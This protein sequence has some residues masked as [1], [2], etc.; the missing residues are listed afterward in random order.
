MSSR[1]WVAEMFDFLH[2]TVPTTLKELMEFRAEAVALR[3]PP[4]REQAVLDRVLWEACELRQQ[5]RNVLAKCPTSLRTSLESELL[6][7]DL[8]SEDVWNS[9]P[10]H[11][12]SELDWL[13]LEKEVQ[14]YGMAR[15]QLQQV[16]ALAQPQQ[17]STSPTFASVSLAANGSVID[18]MNA[19]SHVALKTNG[20]SSGR[21]KPVAD[22]A[23][24]PVEDLRALHKRMCTQP[25]LV[26]LRP[27]IEPVGRLLAATEALNEEVE[28]FVQKA[29]VCSVRKYR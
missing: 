5:A 18:A 24:W 27:L 8:V 6:G 28:A 7:A 26:I 12:S 29:L 11:A 17:R 3:L 19:S 2:G 21:A 1:K 23:K 14:A 10:T 15:R 16:Q 9:L 20:T 13:A 25:P 4:L 22:K